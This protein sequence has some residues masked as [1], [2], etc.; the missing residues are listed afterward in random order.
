MLN[1][2]SDVSSIRKVLL[3]VSD[4]PDIAILAGPRHCVLSGTS[5]QVEAVAEILTGSGIKTKLVQLSG[6][7][8]HSAVLDKALS[9][10]SLPAANQNPADC[11]Y[12]SGLL[13]QEITGDRLGSTY[14]VRHMRDRV[15]F[16]DAMDY[17]RT[18]LSDY[19]LVD[20][21]PGPA[22]TSIISR[23]GW[24]SIEPVSVDVYLATK[25]NT[26][27]RSAVTATRP[28]ETK[29]DMTK[30]TANQTG[31]GGLNSVDQAAVDILASNFGYNDYS[32]DYLLSK[33][34]LDLGLQSLDFINFSQR[35]SQVAGNSIPAHFY[36]SQRS[37]SELLCIFFPA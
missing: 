16:F 4:P 35:L 17:I 18:H 14:W 29:S 30:K 13:G 1:A 27:P 20:M 11:T 28:E 2:F 22:V 15:H 37:I 9:T 8:F 32:A 21:G 23:Y 3:G 33:S 25:G 31:E 5:A 19:P 36:S 7:P 26:A 34:F 10:L 12:I 6:I 24:E